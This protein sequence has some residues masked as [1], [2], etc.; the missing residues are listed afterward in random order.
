[1]SEVLSAIY[2]L[3]ASLTYM[4]IL[5]VNVC[6]DI[7]LIN[8]MKKIRQFRLFVPQIA[9]YTPDLTLRGKSGVGPY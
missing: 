3:R 1:M 2:N 6:Y 5:Y 9:V 8:T 4:V 7:C